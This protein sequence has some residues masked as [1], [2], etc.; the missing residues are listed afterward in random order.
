MIFNATAHPINIY[1]K[2]DCEYNEQLRKW[3]VKKGAKPVKVIAP[4]GRILNAHTN[5]ILLQHVEDIPLWT[6]SI[7]DIDDPIDVFG[8]LKSGDI[9][10]VSRQY[11]AAHDLWIKEHKNKLP[12]KLACICHPVYND[13]DNPKPV[14]CLG[15]EIVS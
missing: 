12:Y 8:D 4:S 5:Y 6:S 10:V 7:F 1:R 14:G 15:L 13:L 9:I 3:F 2:E 11:A